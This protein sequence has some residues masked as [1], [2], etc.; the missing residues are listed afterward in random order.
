MILQLKASE[1]SQMS[2]P[3][4]Q[5]THEEEITMLNEL[6]RLFARVRNGE[7]ALQLEEKV[8]TLVKHTH[9]HF[10]RENEQMRIHHFPPYLIHKQVHD[11]HLAEMDEVVAKWKR[12]GDIKPLMTFFE[13]TT[14]EWM[15]QHISTMDFVTANFLAM[16]SN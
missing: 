5:D 1:F 7:E 16:H 3:F 11:Q 9:D 13:E 10:E 2:T 14:P 6:Y 15:R 8:D 4:M 12:S